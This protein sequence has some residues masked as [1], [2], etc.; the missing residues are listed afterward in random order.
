MLSQKH[1][2]SLFRNY[3]M[4]DENIKKN[5]PKNYE[6]MLR[7]RKLKEKLVKLYWS[8]MFKE[9]IK[10]AEEE[11]KLPGGIN[12]PDHGISHW[13]RVKTLGRYLAKYTGADTKVTNYFAFLHDLK[14]DNEG[15]DQY[16]GVRAAVLVDKLQQEG[17]LKLSQKQWVQ[18]I[19]ACTFHC[20]PNEKNNDVTVQTCWDADRLDLVRLG[21][22]PDPAFLNTDKAKE[23]KAIEFAKRLYEDSIK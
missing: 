21:I 4:G 7:L 9:L 20:L 11:F 17:L 5:F 8:K 10:I 22:K 15:N 2:N 12:N 6:R 23:P 14:R 18:L 1:G 16:H 13:N 3:D 19:A